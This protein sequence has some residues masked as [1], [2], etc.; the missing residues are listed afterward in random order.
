VETFEFFDEQYERAERYWWRGDERYALEPDAYATSLLTQ[1]TLRLIQGRAHGRALDI[2]AGEGADSI[3]LALL[4]YSVTA[5]EVSKVGAEK[6][7]MFAEQV[8]VRVQVEAVDILAYEPSGK[9]DVVI[10]NGVLQ[11]V[12]DKKSVINLMQDATRRGGINVISLWSSYTPVP[13]CHSRVAVY[14][15]REDGEVVTSYEKWRTE[16]I[17]FERDKPE[18]SHSDMPA[19]SHSHIKLIARKPLHYK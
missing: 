14:C 6:I 2:G 16:F 5:V 19:H 15:D 17:Y 8:G 9:F 3:R 10:C 12:K 7:L 11:Y 4:G 13:E 18:E 1:M